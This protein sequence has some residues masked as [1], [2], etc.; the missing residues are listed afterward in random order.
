M[1]APAPM[2]YTTE[3]V[4]DLLKISAKTVREMIKSKRLEAVR[5]GKE[6]RIT[7]DQIRKYIKENKT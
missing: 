3:E 5:V 2:F 7:E 6:Y 1:M 4:A